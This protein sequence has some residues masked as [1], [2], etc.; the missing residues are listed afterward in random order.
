VIT[1][2]ARLSRVYAAHVAGAAWHPPLPAAQ[3]RS[4]PCANG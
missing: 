2:P 1:D 4:V 3:W